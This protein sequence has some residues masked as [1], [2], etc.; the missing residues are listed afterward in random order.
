MMTRSF[1]FGWWFILW[2]P[3]SA[4]GQTLAAGSVAGT[5][6]TVNFFAPVPRNFVTNSKLEW[7]LPFNAKQHTF[8]FGPEVRVFA[9]NRLTIKA[10]ALAGVAKRFSLLDPLSQ[11]TDATPPLLRNPSILPADV[12]FTGVNGIAASFGASV[13][14]RVNDHLLYRILQPEFLV[15]PFKTTY[16][17]YD[18][19]VST[20]LRFTFGK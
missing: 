17:D 8:L 11:P 3:A 10:R 14:Y 6:P 20:G 19:R 1:R 15:V 13:D 12:P 2:V 9:T 7:N 4:F 16:K 5:T 18:L